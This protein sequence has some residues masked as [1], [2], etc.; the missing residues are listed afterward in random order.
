METALLIVGIFA[1]ALLMSLSAILSAA[2]VL[3]WRR[4]AKAERR[5]KGTN[6]NVKTLDEILSNLLESLGLGER[7]EQL[8]PQQT[9]PRMRLPRRQRPNA[10]VNEGNG[11]AMNEIDNP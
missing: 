1:V 4:Q 6:R 10:H 8:Q 7:Q 5:I 11:R 2:V 3:L 9:Q